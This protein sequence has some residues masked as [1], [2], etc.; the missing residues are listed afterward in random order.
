MKSHDPKVLKEHVMTGVDPDF[1]KKAK[2]GDIIVAGKNF[3]HG[4]PHVWG[5]QAMRELGLGLV[6]EFMSRGGFRNA[7]AAGLP[8]LPE[9]RGITDK[10]N[11]GDELEVDFSTGEI[12]NLTTGELIKAEPLA[13]P[14]L[15]IIAAGGQKRYLKKKFAGTREK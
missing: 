13:P 15:E 10:V 8:F 9:A 1:P 7:V 14:L 5:Y 11:Q 3:G 12:R 2:P 6:V 4:N